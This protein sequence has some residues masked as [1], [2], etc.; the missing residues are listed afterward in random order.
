[1]FP[2]MALS[3]NVLQPYALQVLLTPIVYFKYVL[4]VA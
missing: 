1:M 3:S 2:V 4:I